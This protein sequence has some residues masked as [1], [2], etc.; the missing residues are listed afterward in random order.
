MT[1]QRVLCNRRMR[2]ALL[3]SGQ[4]LN[5]HD[6][7][8]LLTTSSAKQDLTILL[9]SIS[10][11]DSKFVLKMIFVSWVG[12]IYRY[13]THKQKNWENSFKYV[14]QIGYFQTLHKLLCG[15]W[16]SVDFIIPLMKK[17]HAAGK[18]IDC[19]IFVRNQHFTH[20]H[21]K[22]SW[23]VF[24]S[25]QKIICRTGSQKIEERLFSLVN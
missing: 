2:T 1:C 21:A 17:T 20:F 13:T 10:I 15:W 3:L 6:S 19:L 18:F 11:K 5:F 16:V 7:G 8:S 25:L 9:K 12:T 22:P 14:L 23:K 4:G 24:L